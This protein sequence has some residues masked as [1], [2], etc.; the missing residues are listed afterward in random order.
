MRCE[1]LTRFAAGGSTEE[2]HQY[3][4]ALGGSIECLSYLS[5]K[6]LSHATEVGDCITTFCLGHLFP[7]MQSLWTRQVSW[8]LEVG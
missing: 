7:R 2:R 6:G 3:F 8:S 4:D 1:R 5:A